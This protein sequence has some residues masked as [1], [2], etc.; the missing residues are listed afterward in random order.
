MNLSSKGLYIRTDK[1]RA[2]YRLL[3]DQSPKIHAGKIGMV[4]DI[5]I[6]QPVE[7]IK[8]STST[9]ETEGS[10]SMPSS[11]EELRSVCWVSYPDPR[12]I[13]TSWFRKSLRRFTSR[14]VLSPQKFARPARFYGTIG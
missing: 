7:T 3:R 6:P 4:S 13:S 5:L 11:L 14:R 12:G 1:N 8:A 9:Y 2:R 10:G